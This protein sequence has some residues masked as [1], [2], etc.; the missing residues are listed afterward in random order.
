MRSR[1]PGLRS[2]SSFSRT[3][4]GIVKPNQ[5]ILSMMFFFFL[6]GNPCKTKLKTFV[7]IPVS[8]LP[9]YCIINTG[10]KGINGENRCLPINYWKTKTTK[11][12]KSR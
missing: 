11:S 1:E 8:G 12:T 9:V 5:G 4:P 10:I 3:V 2:T 6:A 7:L